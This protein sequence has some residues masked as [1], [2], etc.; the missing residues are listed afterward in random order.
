VLLVHPADDPQGAA[1]DPRLVL[2]VEPGLGR[3][4]LRRSRHFTLGGRYGSDV[5]IGI[6]GYFIALRSNSPTISSK[7][8]SCVTL[9]RRNRRWHPVSEGLQMGGKKSA[10]ALRR[11]YHCGS[12]ANSS[13]ARETTRGR[14]TFYKTGCTE[15]ATSFL[16]RTIAYSRSRLSQ[17]AVG[18][19]RSSMELVSRGS[20]RLV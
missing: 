18:A 14:T 13:Y 6:N 17:A 7:Y 4:G 12:N 11:C 1:R 20:L 8:V 16:P 5:P 19:D 3:S 15:T 2:D 10:H 9:L